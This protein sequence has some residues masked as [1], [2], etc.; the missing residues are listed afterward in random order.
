MDKPIRIVYNKILELRTPSKED[1]L[2]EA[3][4]IKADGSFNLQ[5][6]SPLGPKFFSGIDSTGILQKLQQAIPF[7]I[8]LP[9]LAT[10]VRQKYTAP[11][12]EI[13][14]KIVLYREYESGI[15]GNV[16]EEEITLLWDD[17]KMGG[18]FPLAVLKMLVDFSRTLDFLA[19]TLKDPR[20][21]GGGI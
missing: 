5:L 3:V 19:A 12:S 10:V 4:D 21:K 20:N 16:M 18:D 1:K 14:K 9:E 6:D 11:E 7:G 15:T 8:F 17:K 2:L 13:F